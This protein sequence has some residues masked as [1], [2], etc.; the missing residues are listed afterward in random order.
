[1]SDAP[2]PSEE[3]RVPPLPARVIGKTESWIVTRVPVAWPLVRV[4][5]RR[6]W[7][8]MASKWDERVD[9]EGQQHL[10]PLVAACDA[11]GDQPGDVLEIGTGTGAGARLLASKFPAARIRALDLSEPMVEQARRR[12]PPEMADRITFEVGDAAAL[13]FPAAS[14][15][16]VTQLNVP[17]RFDELARLVRPGGHVAIASSI[18]PRTPY[19]TPEKLLQRKFAARGFGDIQIGEAG[20]GTYF[21]ARRAR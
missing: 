10:A 1:M 5:T 9:P 11:L 2:P 8:S 16:L 18:G 19:Y 6:W 20:D 14:F 15:D 7:D 13:P 21:V 17:A 4:V 3:P 12:T